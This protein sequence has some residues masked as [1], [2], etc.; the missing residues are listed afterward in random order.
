[1]P[2]LRIRL[3]LDAEEGGL[4]QHQIGQL[5]DFDGADVWAMP[6]VMAGLMVYLAT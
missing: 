4:P 5:A 2:P 6:W 3:G 1:M